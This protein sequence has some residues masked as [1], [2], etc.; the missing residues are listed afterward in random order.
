MKYKV[1]HVKELGN[2]IMPCYEVIVRQKPNFLEYFFGAKTEEFKCVSDF[3]A[4]WYRVD[5]KYKKIKFGSSLDKVLL[6]ILNSKRI[7]YIS[8]LF[9]GIRELKIKTVEESLKNMN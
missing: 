7:A 4:E 8:K 3:G 2:E 1:L 6:E 9:D 5:P